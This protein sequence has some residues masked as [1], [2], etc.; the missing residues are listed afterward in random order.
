M[1]KDTFKEFVIIFVNLNLIIFLILICLFTHQNKPIRTLYEP[2]KSSNQNIWFSFFLIQVLSILFFIR[3]D[4]D[5][6]GK[7]GSGLFL[8]N[9][10]LLGSYDE[11]MNIDGAHYCTMLNVKVK[12][13]TIM[14]RLG[15]VIL[16]EIRSEYFLH[17]KMFSQ[18]SIYLIE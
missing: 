10:Y 15:I 16:K 5:A 13:R 12:I 14:V 4:L 11:C 3:L 17:V 6:L 2:L 8:G 18:S 7:P 1:Q 9:V